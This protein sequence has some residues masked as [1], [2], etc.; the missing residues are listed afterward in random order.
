M[1]RVA[2]HELFLKLAWGITASIS[3]FCAIEDVRN[4]CA[5]RLNLLVVKDN[6]T[7]SVFFSGFDTPTSGAAER[8]WIGVGHEKEYGTQDRHAET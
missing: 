8:G 3:F 7:V 5:S 1:R 6:G 4:Y 2:P